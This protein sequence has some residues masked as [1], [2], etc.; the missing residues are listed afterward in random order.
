[1]AAD[2]PGEG[3]EGSRPVGSRQRAVSAADLAGGTQQQRVCLPAEAERAEWQKR[4]VFGPVWVVQL[5]GALLNYIGNR[6]RD[7]EMGARRLLEASAKTD[8]VAAVGLDR[9]QAQGDL[10]GSQSEEG[11]AAQGM[12]PV[13]YCEW[14]RSAL[15]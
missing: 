3:C 9:L 15:L 13:E 11:D 6:L 4:E 8:E 2:Q 12:Q 10:A 7:D 5:V 1:M 14:M